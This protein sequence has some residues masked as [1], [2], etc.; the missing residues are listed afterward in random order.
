LNTPLGGWRYTHLSCTVEVN[1]D[2]ELTTGGVAMQAMATA[3][4]VLAYPRIRNVETELP[5]AVQ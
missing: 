2:I 3:V 4:S 5:D 1:E